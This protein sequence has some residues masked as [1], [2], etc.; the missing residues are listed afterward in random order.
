MRPLRVALADDE[1]LARTRLARLL[2]EA[3]CEVK[4]ELADGPSVLAWLKGAPDLDA[5]F[6]DI[7][8]PGATGLEVAVELADCRT[9][10][11]VV[12]VT[13]YSEHAV[14]AFEAAAADYILKPVSAERLAKCLAR[15]GEGGPRRSEA[16][17]PLPQ[18]FPVK[19]GEG[20][21]FLDLKRT[22]HFEVETEVVWAWAAG[23]RHRTAWTTL[24]EVEAAFPG[25][26][27]LRIQRHLL[28]RPEAVLG[29]KPLEGGRASVRVGEGLDLEVSRSVTPRLKELLGL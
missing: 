28:L 19:A 26:G 13:A 6:L 9:C 17:G 15:L 7:Q 23:S 29:L 5:L 16:V 20:H 2:R 25:A 8:M 12:F 10:P 27:L 4:A 3:G 22:S 21:V 14:R 1:P 11:P 24:A 18:R